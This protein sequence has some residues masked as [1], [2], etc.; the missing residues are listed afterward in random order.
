MAGRDDYERFELGDFVLEGGATL[1]GAS[2]A[3]KT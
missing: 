3:Y 2:L 1:R